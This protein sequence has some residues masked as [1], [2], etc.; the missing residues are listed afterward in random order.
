[1]DYNPLHT[2][3]PIGPSVANPSAA[4]S[5]G[6]AYVDEYL[7]SDDEDDD[8]FDEDEEMTSQED[9]SEADFAHVSAPQGDESFQ[10]TESIVEQDSRQLDNTGSQSDTTLVPIP[11]DDS[12]AKSQVNQQVA[13]KQHSTVIIRGVAYNT[14]RGL[15]YYVS[16]SFW[17]KWRRSLLTERFSCTLTILSLRHFRRALY[18]RVLSR[19]LLRFHHLLIPKTHLPHPQR[20][21]PTQIQQRQGKNGSGSG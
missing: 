19:L 1:M 3:R 15:L 16:P 17:G 9:T 21:Q 11:I 6:G 4:Q 10:M 8:Y 20:R 13:S 2:P 18:H 7:D 5:E 14:Y 12:T